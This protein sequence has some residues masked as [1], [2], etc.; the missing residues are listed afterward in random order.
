LPNL[1]EFL[2]FPRRWTV[3]TTVAA[4]FALAAHFGCHNDRET[5]IHDFEKGTRPEVR[6]GALTNLAEQ[7]REEDLH[8]FFKGARDSSAL[9]RRAAA[10]GLGNSGD[11]RAVDALGE[12]LADGDVDIQTAAAAG[13][14]RFNNDKARAYLLNAYGRQDAPA[15]AAIA[16][17][18]GPAALAE[19][20]RYEARLLWERNLKALEMG[21][22][23]ERVGAAEELGR[24]GR[25]DAVERLLPLLGDDSV[26]LAAGAARGLR[27]AGD[28]RAVASLVGIIKED[29]PVLREACAEALG[30][31]GD[32]TAIPALLKMGQEG[33]PIAVAAVHALGQLSGAAEARQAL[34]Q[35]AAEGGIEVASL[36]ARLS[37]KAQGC[38]SKDLLSRLSRGTAEAL[39]ALAALEELGGAAG[40]DKVAAL[41]DSPELRVAAAEA[42]GGLDASAV[43]PKLLKLLDAEAQRLGGARQKWVAGP[44]PHRYGEGFETDRAH[45][46]HEQERVKKFNDMMAKVDAL[47]EA[48]SQAL[49]SRPAI[50]EPHGPQELVDDLP[51]A[52]DLFLIALAPTVGKL[53]AA[54]ALPVLEKLSQDERAAI[55]AA[56]CKG[57]GLM[58]EPAALAIAGKCLLDPAPA[59]ILAAAEGL[60]SAGEP[61]VAVLLEGLNRR[62]E[63]APIIRALGELKARPAVARLTALLSEGG[64]EAAEAAE[65]L[66]RIGDPS[67]AAPLAE[68][69]KA[70]ATPVRREAILALGSL[71]ERSVAEVVRQSIFSE[72]PEIRAA[73]ARCLGRLGVRDPALEALRFDYYAEVRRAA[74]EAF[75]K[76]TAE[77][78]PGGK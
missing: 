46:G 1:S 13:L 12:L 78:A 56:A 32:P 71:G 39:P 2:S 5:W 19:A 22:P 65:A 14:A 49:G 24:S 50:A 70:R 53:R 52:D 8:L 76:G 59:V 27:A 20:V 18:L 37:R 34:C 26:L 31:L 25:G 38:P 68:I 36:S 9:V 15:R 4:L 75:G 40:V 33:G 7:G 47:N 64:L 77:A 30:T 54:G 57:L 17:A 55:R 73:A 72:R 62:S 10:V 35:L 16:A 42:L 67:A 74:E 3:L 41:L 58:G 6:A 43:A 11:G 29:Y 44:L 45:A 61:A 51:D 48:R 66:G 28:R 23:A 21:G 69:L 60:Q 63:R